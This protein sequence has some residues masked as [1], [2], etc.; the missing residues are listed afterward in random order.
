M[1]FI[2]DLT[3]TWN[4]G[5]TSFNAIKMN[6]TDT[7]S[8]AASQLITLQ[9]GGS[10]RFGVRKDGQGY[11]AG[12]VGIGTNT[13]ATS[14]SVVT[15]TTIHNG[16][17]VTNNSTTQFAGAGLQMLG[18]SAAG[19]QGGAAI[20]YFNTTVGGTQGAL[21][22][23]QLSSGGIFQRSLATYDFNAQYWA[24]LTSDTER[25]RITSAGNVGIGTSAPAAR[26]DVSGT[27]RNRLDL[28]SVTA[29]WVTTNAAAN[30]YAE[31]AHDALAH[32]WLISSANAMVLNTSGNVG[33]GTSSPGARLD[34]NAGALGGTAGNTLDLSRFFGQTGGNQRTLTTTLV[35]NSNG[36][37]WTTTTM[38]LQAVVDATN[39]TYVDFSPN[40]THD[41]A[42]GSL[43][44]ERMRITSAGNVGIGTTNPSERL[45]TGTGNI[46]TQALI[47]SGNQHLLYSA[48]ANTLGLRIGAAGPF[49]GI[50]TTGSNNMRFNNASGGDM[51]FAIAA[52][53]RMRI[54]NTG[55]VLIGTTVGGRTVCVNSSDTWLRLSNPSRSWLLGMGVTNSFF[56]WDE[57][58]GGARL[59]IDTSGNVGIGTT[60][61]SRRLDVVGGALTAGTQSSYAVGVANSGGA[62]GDLTFGSD[63]SFSYVQSWAGKPLIING[64]GN[65]VRMAGTIDRGAF[66]LQVNGTG[67]W[68]AGAYV[69]GSD[70]NLKEEI[71]PL[72][73]ALDVVAALKPVT[74][75]YKEE[76]SKDQSIQPGFIAQEL[77]EALVDQVY[78]DGIV[79][80]GPEHLNVAYQSLIPVLVKA[81][82]ELTARVAQLEGN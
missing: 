27:S 66:N 31:I 80:A 18:P 32:R 12:N 36:S 39:S 77:Q 44:S 70:R 7:A 72:A 1:A 14:L 16:M 3:D 62:N 40:G 43:G 24:F 82:Q 58:G 8:A 19:S 71:A 35:R 78:L 34:V 57:S 15:N 56:I 60:V 64:Q 79:Q 63:G 67:V 11:F 5:G 21:G 55:E 74:F 48:D 17:R 47:I 25:M 41:L 29:S 69:N 26:L 42:F 30:A 61:P 75:R 6:V 38:R 20:Y 28:S 2:Y 46:R 76:Y 45:D 33:I 9:V 54:A 53:E 10:E 37:D 4:A 68:G 49:Y 59:M 51:L 81:I 52:T 50:G 23:A 65:V 22:I 13:P 73:D